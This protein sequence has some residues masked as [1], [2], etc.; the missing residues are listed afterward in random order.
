MRARLAALVAVASLLTLGV[1]AASASC[2]QTEFG[3]VE[4]LACAAVGVV[5]KNVD[6]VE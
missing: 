2:H 5:V 1:P 4:D 6:C 3:C